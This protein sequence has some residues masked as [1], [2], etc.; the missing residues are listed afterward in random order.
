M[1]RFMPGSAPY[2]AI[3][4]LKPSG[5]GV[6]EALSLVSEAMSSVMDR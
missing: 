4:W 1:F 3:H 2:Q 5:K 6:R